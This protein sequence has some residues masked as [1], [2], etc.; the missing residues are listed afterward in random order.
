[1]S[2][3]SSLFLSARWSPNHDENLGKIAEYIGTKYR[4]QIKQ[5]PDGIWHAA[6]LDYFRE[7][8]FENLIESLD[9]GYIDSYSDETKTFGYRKYHLSEVYFVVLNENGNGFSNYKF[10]CPMKFLGGKN[11]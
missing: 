10:D 9:W 6:G 11:G 7:D 3:Y 2:V 4:V 8:E 5:L 1:M